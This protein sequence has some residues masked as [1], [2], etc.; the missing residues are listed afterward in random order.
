MHCS[1][2]SY[3]STSGGLAHRAKKANLKEYCKEYNEKKKLWLQELRAE[4]DECAAT[5]VEMD[6]G[7]AVE[8]A[9]L[10]AKKEKARQSTKKWKNV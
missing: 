3:L 7:R 8:L 2:L 1:M 9:T 10:L 4:A 6:S 5:C